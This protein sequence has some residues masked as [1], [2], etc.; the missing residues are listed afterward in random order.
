VFPSAGSP[1]RA[2]APAYRADVLTPTV[3][4]PVPHTPLL[5]RL[6][7]ASAL[8]RAPARRNVPVEQI[9]E[10]REDARLSR[11]RLIALAA[12]GAGLAACE[13]GERLVGLAPRAAR[14][15]DSRARVV[16]VGAGL[17]GLTCAYRLKQAGIAA[18]VY[19]ASGRVGGRCFTQYGHF[20]DGQIA[21]R[22]GEL[23]DQSHTEIRQLAQE[24][25]LDLD[26]LL[27]AE[28]SGTEPFYFFDGSRYAYADA[29]RDLKAAWQ[30]LHRDLSDASY[31][32]LYTS[33]TPRGFQ[34]D[35]MSIAE[36]IDASI[37]GGRASR[38][39]QLLETAYVIEYGAEAAEQSALNLIYLLGYSGQGQLRIFG[40][41]N[42]K[43]RV[44]GGNDQ[45]AARLAAALSGQIVT[46]APL[47][48]IARTSAGG[49]ALTFGGGRTVTADKVVLTI[50]FSVL[51]SSVDY[52]R[53]GFNAIKQT[54]IREL[55]MG[56]NAKLT[57]QFTSR[58]WSAIGGNGETYADAG[59]Q[60]T[61]DA[62][63]AQAGAAGLLVDYTG[64]R[65]TLALA[66]VTAAEAT[67]RFLGQIEPVFPGL[68]ARWNG[69]STLDYW[70]GDPWTKGSYSFWK[71]GQYTRFAGAEGERS[72]NCHFAGEHTSIDSQGYLNG[73]VESGE[74]A[75]R[76][77][78]ADLGLRASA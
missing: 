66:G 24:L 8:A 44:R 77:V 62:S 55:G 45:V 19:E 73:A 22:G 29:T 13:R 60:A 20:A 11:R 67:R 69:R 38:L 74:R 51:R 52:G 7:E 35:H 50:P 31:P 64:G 63:R 57:V 1:A 59:Y 56:A 41:S 28:A 34:L 16:I 65:T 33:F 17:A 76:E 72:G 18:T 25:G 3:R 42:E 14:T 75:A 30:T 37:P 39:G 53:A 58:H 48:A 4:L 46:G 61:W 10:E 6:L 9:I 21:E 2:A 32:T 49:Y 71:V 40:P 27:R 68:S 5:Q 43:Y 47:V 54:A 26:N 70:P 23:I 36:W 12:A 78:A 15:P